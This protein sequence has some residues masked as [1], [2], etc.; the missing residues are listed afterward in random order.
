[1]LPS[2]YIL[3]A[4]GMFF[5]DHKNNDAATISYHFKNTDCL[6]FL[7]ENDVLIWDRGYRDANQEAN[8]NKLVTFMPSLLDKKSK[9]FTCE[10]ANKTKTVTSTRWVVEAVNG[11][12]KGVFPFFKHKIEATYIPKL[13]L[14]NQ[15]AC[16]IL[17]KYF[18]P[19]LQDQDYHDLIA[20]A[21]INQNSNENE[22]KEEVERLGLTRMTA[23]WEKCSTDSVQDFPKLSWDDLKKLTLGSYQLR[24]AKKYNQQHVKE[25]GTY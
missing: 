4:D 19:I 24:I 10:E 23:K 15:I 6:L 20:D 12:Y 25:D 11:R 14:F 2:G 1:M 3:A 13:L 7:E 22:L 8:N 18:P 16:A 17:N 9:Q 5:C 21:A